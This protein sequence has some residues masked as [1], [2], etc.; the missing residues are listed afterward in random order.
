MFVWKGALSAL[1][2]LLMALLELV[3]VRSAGS[4]RCTFE[5][6]MVRTICG[7][8]FYVSLY[9]TAKETSLASLCMNP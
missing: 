4:G 1:T 3:K 5:K 6:S 7:L 9:S 8:K 2:I